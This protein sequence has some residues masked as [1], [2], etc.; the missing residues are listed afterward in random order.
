MN[1]GTFIRLDRLTKF[2]SDNLSGN[3]LMEVIVKYNGDIQR[4]GTELGTVVELLSVNYAI[5][6]IS[7]NRLP[8]LYDYREVEYIEL[9]KNLTYILRYSLESGCITPVQSRTGLGLS[10]KG[11]AVGIIDSGIDYSHP[12]FINS[13]GSSRILYI[14]DQTITGSPPEGFRSGTEYTNSQINEALSQT[15]HTLIVPSVDTIGHGTAVAGIAVGNGSTS[16]GLERGVAPEASI[17]VVKIGNTGNES[18][19]RSTE[20]M[21]AV[22]YLSDKAITLNMPL[23][24][25]ISY[26]TNNGSHDGNSLFERYIDSMCEKWKTVIAVAT[27]NEG[28][29]SHHFYAKL[30]QGETANAEFVLTGNARSVYITIW[31]NF[32]DTIYFELISPG[33][34]STGIIR[35]VQSVTRITLDG[36]SVSVLYGQPNHYRAEQEVYFLLQ[37][38][39]QVISPGIWTISARGTRITD[40]GFNVWLPTGEEVSRETSFLNPSLNTTL[41]LP[42]TARNIIAVGGYNAYINISADFSGRGPLRAVDIIRPDLVAPAV[43]IYTTRTGGGYDTYT[44]T[45]MAVPFV[46]G[47]AA[48]MMEWGIIRGNDPFLYGQRVTAF[49]RRG[50]ARDFPIIYPNNIWGYGTLSLC[51]TMNELIEYSSGGGAFS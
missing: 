18:F 44:G 5:I 26:G 8:S 17:I 36:V 23:V 40:G 16:N 49:L 21:R 45:S 27:G 24:I 50:A 2:Q 9:P 41:T 4:V 31:K 14:W 38:Q 33:G 29:T 11:V 42:S 35:P 43:D 32:A 28:I 34:D 10:G 30:T 25:N 3:D 1:D 48:L 51:N 19:A 46:T 22:K 7:L 20:I 37:T 47:S 39:N 13:D 12:D 15:Q 6:T